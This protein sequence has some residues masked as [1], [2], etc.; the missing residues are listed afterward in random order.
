MLKHWKW[1]LLVLGSIAA[2]MAYFGYTMIYS[3]NVPSN[4]EKTSI[5]IPQGTNFDALTDT[6][7]ANGIIEDVSSFRMVSKIMKFDT[8]EN[9]SGRFEIKPGWSNRELVTLLR[10]NRQAPINV[11]INN[12][13]LISDM[14]GKVASYIEPDSLTLLK[15]LTDNDNL[16][17]WGYTSETILSLFIPHL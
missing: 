1:I 17:K 8:R 10:A 2:G 7:T 6:L 15:Y 14:A 5:N 11:T 16:A 9:I 3:P 12:V 4:L 13:R